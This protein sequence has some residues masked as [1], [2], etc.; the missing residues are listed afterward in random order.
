MFRVNPAERPDPLSVRRVG[1]LTFHRCFNYGSYWQA[2][3]LVEGLAAAGYPVELLDHDSAEVS[4]AEARC[5]M[6]PALPER[7]A[8]GD[9]PAYKAKARR[10]A[11]AFA[12]LPMSRPFPLD[13]PASAGRYDAVVVGSDE[14][15]NFEHPWY[16]G[17]P[18]FFGDGLKAGRLV[19]YAASFGNHDAIGGIDRWW[20]GRLAAFDALSV[21]D[22]NS[23]RIVA[24][25]L[26]REPPLVL[27]PCLQFP[28]VIPRAP[29]D[30]E[31]PYLLIYGH[32]FPAWL[33]AALHRWSRRT[34]VRL[35]S[36]G[37][38]N[39]WADAHAIA[40]GPLD[41]A[42][43]MAGAAAVATNFFHGCVFA[44]VNDKPLVTAPTSYRFNKIRDLAAALAFADRIVDEDAPQRQLDALLDTPPGPHVAERL[45]AL[46][47]QSAD[48][49]RAALA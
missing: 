34:G 49:L 23:Q 22:A 42:R 48:Y 20:S 40:A 28:E 1:V 27:D 35:L 45:T 33:Q 7:S 15:W 10:F 14:V 11:E 17:K 41:F 3:C 24:E 12:A 39:A 36:V 46:R 47:R 19:S 43:L 5:L 6:Q 30:T 25:A 4:R 8:R 9:F 37:Y 32:G 2:R 13:A 31:E 29:A 26:G 21:R 44:L 38:R 18:I 16:G